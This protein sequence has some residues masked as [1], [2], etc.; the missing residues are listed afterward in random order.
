MIPVKCVV[1]VYI[2]RTLHNKV[3]KANFN[4]HLETLKYLW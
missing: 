3:D 2:K 1:G 4:K